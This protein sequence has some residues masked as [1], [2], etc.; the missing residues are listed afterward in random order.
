MR[1]YLVVPKE[2]LFL[3]YE[4]ISVPFI[5]IKPLFHLTVCLWMFWPAPDVFYAVICKI[6]LKYAAIRKA[7]MVAGKLAS[8]V[9][10]YLLKL[11]IVFICIFDYADACFSSGIAGFHKPKQRPAGIIFQCPNP[12]AII[13]PLMPVHM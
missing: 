5:G 12:Y 9:C 3:A 13:G 11:A 4:R 10:K 7:R 6:L 8:P 1:P 2:E